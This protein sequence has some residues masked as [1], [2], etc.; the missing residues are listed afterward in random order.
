[1]SYGGFAT[2]RP[3][4]YDTILTSCNKT[5]DDKPI[6][7]KRRGIVGRVLSSGIVPYRVVLSYVGLLRGICGG[8]MPILSQSDRQSQAS[9]SNAAGERLS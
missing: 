6:K 4:Y 9:R 8:V 1:M 3:N 7:L 2:A 5:P